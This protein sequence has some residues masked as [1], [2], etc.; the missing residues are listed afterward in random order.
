VAPGKVF[1]SLEAAICPN[2][3][4]ITLEDVRDSLLKL[5]FPIEIP[6]DTLERARVPLERMLV[7]GA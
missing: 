2:M 1:Y 4:E 6:K 5:Q 3:R 7:A